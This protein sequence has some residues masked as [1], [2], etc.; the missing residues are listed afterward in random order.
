M[1]IFYGLLLSIIV[2]IFCC[3]RSS[4]CLFVKINGLGNVPV[5]VGLA[6]PSGKGFKG[7]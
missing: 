2:I 5:S 1:R 7:G 4:F 6:L 3:C